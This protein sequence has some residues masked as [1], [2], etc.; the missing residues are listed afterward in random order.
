MALATDIS[1]QTRLGLHVTQ[2]ELNIWKQRAQSGPYKSTGDVRTNSPGDWDRIVSKKNTFNGNPTGQ[3]WAGQTVNSCATGYNPEPGQGQGDLIVAASFYSLVA[4][5]ATTRANVRAELLA[6]AATAGTDF[7]NRTRWCINLP[8]GPMT[9]D[10][11][12]IGNWLTRLLFAYDYIRPTLST[13]DRI[14][15]DTWF[16]NAGYYLAKILDSYMVAA[17]FPGRDTNNY[18][19]PTNNGVKGADYFKTHDGGYQSDGWTESWNNRAAAQIRA[20]GLIGVM[21]ND[22]YLKDQGKRYCEEWIKYAVFADGTIGEMYRSASDIVN[23]QPFPSHGF[24]YAMLTL[25]PCLSI[26]DAFA[27]TGD[28]ELYTYSTSAGYNGTAGGPKSL[29]QIINLVMR[30][31]NHDVTRYVDGHSGVANYVIDVNDE[32]QGENI[33][34]DTYIA[35]ANIYYRSNYVK[36]IYMRTAANAPAYPAGGGA[37]GGYP[38][39]TGEWGVYPGILFMFG[40]MEGNVSP[41]PTGGLQL[42][43]I[44][45]TAAPD[46]VISAQSSVLTWSTS[47][48]TSCTG[49]G[50]WT[51]IVPTSG[52]QTVSLTQSTTYTLSCTGAGGTASQSTTITVSAPPNAP[53][54]LTASVVP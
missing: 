44:N 23:G 34:D 50:G 24:S 31:V 14:T 25:A 53:T 38:A 29:S 3:R 15:L 33:V 52:T 11:P 32:L 54:S 1:A 43:S 6:Q 26:A 49:S 51:G 45:F 46:T 21:L 12:T 18:S 42:P 17:K 16:Y 41:Y 22:A 35:Q 4:N 39:W 13:S 7:S 5:D 28:F 37:T 40:Q 36:S 48:A 20:S 8:Y 10:A 30:Y 9:D 47:N 19:N 27:R 2:E